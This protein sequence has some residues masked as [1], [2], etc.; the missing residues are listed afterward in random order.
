M[1]APTTQEEVDRRENLSNKVALVSDIMTIVA[2]M[3]DPSIKLRIL[4]SLLSDTLSNPEVIS[5][6][7]EQIDK[8]EVQDEGS[9]DM[10]FSEDMSTEDTDLSDLYSEDPLASDNMSLSDAGS[11]GEAPFESDASLPTPSDLGIG[12]LSDSTNPEL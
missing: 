11:Y 2:D 5:L 6:I 12:D 9:E 4:K 1:L 10:K 8:L 3:E 7:Q